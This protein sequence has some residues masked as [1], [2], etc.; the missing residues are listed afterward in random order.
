MKGGPDF[1]DPEGEFLNDMIDEVDGIGLRVVL[2]YFKSP[3]SGCI[4][5][6]SILESAYLL[7]GFSYESQK[8]DIYLDVMAGHLFLISFG[9]NFAG[10]R[11]A[12][13]A[14]QVVAAQDSVNAGIRDF[15][16]MV[17]FKIPR[18]PD[19]PQ[20]VFFPE[21]QNLFFDCWRRSVA[22][23]LGMVL[24]LIRPTSPRS[25]YAFFHR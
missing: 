25:A 20:V 19:W 9:M 24:P 13:K 14:V 2:I 18:D 8:L 10:A 11:P 7:T 4:V 16:A 23:H 21:M 17:S 12:R 5:D 3:H 15:D 1:F 6:G 22:C